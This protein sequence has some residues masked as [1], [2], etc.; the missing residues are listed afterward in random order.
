MKRYRYL[1]LILL[2]LFAAT[3]LHAET[4]TS[5][6]VIETDNRGLPRVHVSSAP[7]LGLVLSGGSSRGI[8]HIGII[9][10]LEKH[11]LQPDLVIGTSM[12][13]IIGGLYAAGYTPSEMTREIETLDWTTLFFDPPRRQVQSLWHK[14][15]QNHLLLTLGLKDDKIRI[16]SGFLRAHL[17]YNMLNDRTIRASFLADFDFRYLPHPFRTVATNLQ[18]GEVYVFDRGPLA[19][20]M[21]AS[22]AVPISFTPFVK[23]SVYLVDGGLVNNMPTDLARAA[24][25]DYVI[26]CD[27]VS[28]MHLYKEFDTLSLVAGQTLKVIV[29]QQTLAASEH[30]DIVIEPDLGKHRGYDFSGLQ[31]IIEKGREATRSHL[32]SIRIGLT[33]MT[34]QPLGVCRRVRI[35][36]NTGRTDAFY[37]QFIQI[38]RQ[39]S[40][41]R[42]DLNTFLQKIWETGRVR[43][44][45]IVIETRQDSCVA[46]LHVVENSSVQQIKFE[47]NSRLSHLLLTNMLGVPR[48]RPLNWNLLRAGVARIDSLYLQRGFTLG[49]VDSV[50]FID[51]TLTVWLEEGRIQQVRFDG[52]HHTKKRILRAMTTVRKGQFFRLPAVQQDVERLYGLGFFDA[53]RYRVEKRPEGGITLIYEVIEKPAGQLQFGARYDDRDR[54]V[55]AIRIGTNNLV[56]TGRQLFA[57]MRYGGY[58]LFSLEYLGLDIA[59][60]YRISFKTS[61]HERKQFRWDRTTRKKTHSTEY[62]WVN[63]ASVSRPLLLNRLDGLFSLELNRAVYKENDFAPDGRCI[64]VTSG[65]YYDTLDDLAFPSQGQRWIGRGRVSD[66]GFGSE[67]DFAQF[68]FMGQVALS[69]MP[70]VTV[71]PEW[72][73]NTADGDVPRQHL[74]TYGGAT[75]FPGL[76]QDAYEFMDATRLGLD[77]R[78]RLKQ[79][80]SDLRQAFFV[81]AGVDMIFSDENMHREWQQP[82]VA[83]VLGV[84]L[85]TL[86]GP[87]DLSWGMAEMGRHHLYLSIGHYFP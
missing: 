1:S 34:D 69:P 78:V 87:V 19:D 40:L 41:T 53:V 7:R 9:D 20:A 79:F 16:P 62:Q 26:A 31:H 54:F 68:E 44:A 11:G 45:R 56:G 43:N 18:T 49:A 84:Q 52:A 15:H 59:T 76:A 12:G 47:G 72:Q 58:K 63:R 83:G 50:A 6:L 13:S 82:E 36:G 74:T 33:K 38:D 17:V 2:F 73:F 28:P 70:S 8:V 64:S 3:R 66:D 67:F 14:R 60:P 51:N 75:S 24:G 77:V 46:T 4:A 25:M 48:N 55:G 85:K 39:K 30:A 10:A 86:L 29:K 65:L 80:R 22:M 57:E 27:A 81:R 71:L 61:Y 5:N 32:D 21:R 35:Q 37:R 23:D 42:A